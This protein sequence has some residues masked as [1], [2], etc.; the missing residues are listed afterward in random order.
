VA[1]EAARSS[2]PTASTAGVR[3]TIAEA[4]DD[5]MAGTS[6]ARLLMLSRVIDVPR[7]RDRR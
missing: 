2:K 7:E 6:G 5:V 4:S 1:S 3:I